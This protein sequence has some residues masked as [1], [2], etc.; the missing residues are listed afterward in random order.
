MWLNWG[1]SRNLGKHFNM[2]LGRVFSETAANSQV[3]KI[4][5]MLEHHV[6]GWSGE[7]ASHRK[8]FNFSHGG[9]LACGSRDSTNSSLTRNLGSWSPVGVSSLVSLALRPLNSNWAM[10]L[11]CQ[12]LQPVDSLLLDFSAAVI[13][14][15]FYMFLAVCSIIWSLYRTQYNNLS[16]EFHLF[17]YL[18]PFL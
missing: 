14:W 9:M 7:T 3:R 15:T 12:D 13:M 2:C 8:Y 6:V 18:P 1:P 11:A 10:L 16:A 4:H 5:S 17:L